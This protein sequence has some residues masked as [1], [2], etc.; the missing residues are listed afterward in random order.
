MTEEP[1][2]TEETPQQAPALGPNVKNGDI[3]LS[4]KAAP[5]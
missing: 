4:A 1:Q 2:M 5:T 3:A